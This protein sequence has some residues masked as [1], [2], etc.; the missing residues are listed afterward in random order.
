[1]MSHHEAW[2]L[3]PDLAAGTADPE[4]R[5]ELDR[6][7]A[8]CA[9]CRTELES[10]RSAVA[11]LAGAPPPV[12][13]PASL[14]ERVLVIPHQSAPARHRPVPTLG[15]RGQRRRPPLRWLAAAAVLVVALAGVA[16]AEV[17]REHG[18]EAQERIAMGAQPI[19]PGAWGEFLIGH[20]DGANTPVRVQVYKLGHLYPGAF[21]EV[22]LGKKG[23]RYS[24]GK[25]S[26]DTHGNA[27]V[28]LNMP[29]GA[30]DEYAWVWVT[31]EHD[32]GNPAPSDATV[33]RG[34]L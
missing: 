11:V 1:M 26:V 33:L 9:A 18:F 28:E 31:R 2:E 12:E 21:Y 27:T 13:P 29:T 7:V 15:R 32:D 30:A 17:R 20:A 5:S 10:L 22:W 16:T 8:D 4:V 3:L 19:A 25:L 6:H 14:R 34:L 23:Q 24:L